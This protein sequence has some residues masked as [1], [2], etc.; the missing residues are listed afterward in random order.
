MTDS[1]LNPRELDLGRL[2]SLRIRLAA[3]LA[4]E[5]QGLAN[6]KAL[7][8]QRAVL[9]AI[10]AS[11]LQAKTSKAASL[12]AAIS[13]A[14]S[15]VAS[16]SVDA[17]SDPGGVVRAR[18]AR[19]NAGLSQIH[20]AHCSM[21]GTDGPRRCV[22]EFDDIFDSER[23]FVEAAYRNASGAPLNALTVQLEFVSLAPTHSETI[24]GSCRYDDNEAP[25][26]YRSLVALEIK[27]DSFDWRALCG[28]PYVLMHEILCHAFQGLNGVERALADHQC[29]WSEG[30]MDYI[31]LLC[32]ETWLAKAAN[33]PAW[34]RNSNSNVRIEAIKLHDGRFPRPG[35]A[36]SGWLSSR[37]NARNAA[38]SLER[39]Y[40]GASRTTFYADLRLLRFSLRFNLEAIPQ[41]ARNDIVGELGLALEGMSGDQ[42]RDDAVAACERFAEDGNWADF[43][44]VLIS[45]N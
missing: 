26:S 20:C 27:D 5:D 25:R 32:T 1:V 36:L 11:A 17:T 12:G 28:V 43:L 13:A 42:K 29:A 8:S 7:D 35:A 34:V 22:S 4:F 44:N 39:I 2:A 19:F 3:A 10:D 45:L 31:A 15:A 40:Q 21:G 6:A 14:T 24:S 23:A 18:L 16:F 33:V 9:G 37:V 30:W 38:R 41:K